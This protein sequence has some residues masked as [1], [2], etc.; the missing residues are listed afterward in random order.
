METYRNKLKIQNLFNVFGILIALALIIFVNV[1]LPQAGYVLPSS[2]ARW[3][4]FWN[5]FI[6]GV[7]SAFVM[8]ALLG[9]VQNIRAL[10]NEEKLRA[11]YIKEHD[12]RTLEIWKRSGAN[13]YWF[14][15]MGMLLAAVVA[16]YFSPVAFLC[17][18]GCLLY[19]CLI[20][21]ALKVYYGK[22]L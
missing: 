13:A 20:R 9:L 5:G 14:D 16:G 11:M 1:Y 3:R 21:L 17:I 19:M 8:L 10:H 12:E 4:G 22:K 7:S 18:L 2:E 15:T 6:S